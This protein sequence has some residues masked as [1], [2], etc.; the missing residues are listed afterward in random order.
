MASTY[1]YISIAALLVTI[2]FL[3]IIVRNSARENNVLAT[4][5]IPVQN[6]VLTSFASTT[7]NASAG[8]VFD[9]L[10]SFKDYDKWSSWSHHKWEET[11]ADGV[12]VVGSK[13]TTKV[14]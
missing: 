7:I 12:P 1:L 14:R 11:A 6:A 8:E 10:T 9:I 13:G 5:S 3:I 2:L 4:P